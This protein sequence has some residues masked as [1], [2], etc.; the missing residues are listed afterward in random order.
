MQVSCACFFR[1]ATD[2]DLKSDLPHVTL[3]APE[4]RPLFPRKRGAHLHY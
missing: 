3:T 4:A 1:P 2:V